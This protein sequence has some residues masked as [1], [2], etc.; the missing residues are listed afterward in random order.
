MKKLNLRGKDLRKIGY[1]EGKVISVII[2]IVQKHYKRYRKKEILDILSDVLENPEKYKNHDIL[3]KIVEELNPKKKEKHKEIALNPEIKDYKIYGEKEIEFGAIQQMNTAMQLP[4]SEKGALMPDA[5]L[6]Y[7][8]PIGGVLATNNVIIP[9][10]VGMDIGCRMCMSV[11]DISPSIIKKDKTRLINI[12]EDNTRFGKHSFKS[13]MDDPIME[14]KEFKEIKILR[15]LK[16]KA[17]SQL[18]T[19]GFGNHFVDVGIFEIIDVNNEFNLLPG[20]YFA[21]LSHSGS[22]G[23]GAGIAKYYT[24]IAMELCKLPKGAKHLAWLGLDT[25]EGQEY[26]QVMNLAGDYSAANHSHI[27]L[28]LSNALK[29]KPLVKIENH[30]NFAWKE[31]LENGKDVIVHRKGATPAHKGVLGIIP[32]SMATP[33]YIVR[34]K[35]NSESINSAAHGAGRLM[36]RSKAKQIIKR[37]EMNQ[38][39]EKAGIYLLGGGLDEAPMV[40]KD[41]NKVM[42]YQEELVEVIGIFYPKI[43]KME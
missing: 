9:Y 14:R 29:T 41:I 3:R 16:A 32:G 21:I 7:G 37:K 24:N 31:K 20:N 42:K 25:Q 30:H 4:V 36:S 10:G 35:G 23:M 18:G 5:H 6:G 19:S 15:E 27:H 11:Y 22:R 2:N 34:G 12:L 17:F 40:Y 13:P 8:L 28:R 43:V 26:W 1:P 39:L 33:A 38:V